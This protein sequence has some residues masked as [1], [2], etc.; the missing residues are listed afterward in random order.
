MMMYLKVLSSFT[1]SMGV[2]QFVV[3]RSVFS[4]KFH[5]GDGDGQKTKIVFVAVEKIFK[6][7]R[8]GTRGGDT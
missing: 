5:A 7:G 1:L 3:V 6:A 4:C 8:S 2:T